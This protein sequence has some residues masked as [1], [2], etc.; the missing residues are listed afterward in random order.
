MQYLKFMAKYGRSYETKEE[1]ALRS[2]L[3]R[4]ALQAITES[5]SRND[6]DYRL[7]VNKFADWTPEEYKALLG[8]K[9]SDGMLGD[10]IVKM[11]PTDKLPASIDWR[12]KGGVNT[13][14]N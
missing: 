14:Q 5:N 6:V 9:K 11:L 2:S 4:K 10:G 7:A 8:Y 3:F 12:Q 1:F 13:V